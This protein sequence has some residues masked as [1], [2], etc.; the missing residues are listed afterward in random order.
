MERA[1]RVSIIE[2]GKSL[3][4]SMIEFHHP[5]ESTKSNKSHHYSDTNVRIKEVA[6]EKSEVHKIKK[7]S[8]INYKENTIRN[9]VTSNKRVNIFHLY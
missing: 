8:R 9:N 5:V 7:S 6:M 1:K 4:K 2:Y 3:K